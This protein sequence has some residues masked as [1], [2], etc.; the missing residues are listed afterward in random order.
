MNS[1]KEAK[2]LYERFYKQMRKYVWDI[3]T[4]ALLAQFE[5]DLYQA[6]PDMEVVRKS[7]SRL[8]RAIKFVSDKDEELEKTIENLQDYIDSDNKYFME[9]AEF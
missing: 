9:I 7:F 1:L 5:V 3:Q 4:V 6:F 2:I 8:R